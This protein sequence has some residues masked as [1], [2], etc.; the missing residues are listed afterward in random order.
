M[1]KYIILSFC[2]K[3]FL[4]LLVLLCGFT[5]SVDA[6]LDSSIDKDSVFYDDKFVEC[7]GLDSGTNFTGGEIPKFVFQFL[8]D[9]TRGFTDFQAAGIM[10]NMKRESGINPAAIEDLRKRGDDLGPGHGLVQ[11]SFGRWDNLQKYATERKKD[12]TDLGVQLDF[13]WLELNSTEKKARDSVKASKTIEEA[14]AAFERDFERAGVVALAE[15][16]KFAKEILDLS[17]DWGGPGAPVTGTAGT[18]QC[19]DA[20]SGNGAVAGNIIAT[21]LNYSWPDN[22]GHKG[23]NSAK[24]E[25]KAAWNGASNM[26]DC[27]AFVATVMV[28]SG[29]D[30]NYPPVGTAIQ[31]KYLLDHPEKYKITHAPKNSSQLLPGDILI[32]NNGGPTGHTMFYVGPQPGGYITAD[33]SLGDHTP[34][35]GSPGNLTWMLSQPNV[36]AAT[37]IK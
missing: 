31:K 32:F 16:I 9:P 12:W 23:P 25:Y 34:Q 3:G 36:I 13:L 29:V 6:A 22:K 30:P 15:R 4:L 37:V 17:R 24:P 19:A 5:N 7:G 33:A 18:V 8:T 14:T 11:W 28:K 35:L 26:T 2:K 10:G 27:G 20:S 21:A 1:K